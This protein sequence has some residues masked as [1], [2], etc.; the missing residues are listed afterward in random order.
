MAETKNIPGAWPLKVG[1]TFTLTRESNVSSTG[2]DWRLIR[3]KN[4]AL[5][6]EHLEQILPLVHG[7]PQADH[8]IGATGKRIWTFQAVAAGDGETQFAKYRASD[9]KTI[10]FDE[11]CPYSITKADAATAAQGG[12]GIQIETWLPFVQAGA[13]ILKGVIGVGV[14]YTPLLAS[15]TA[16]G[17]ETLVFANAKVVAPRTHTYPVA[18]WL[19]NDGGKPV[20]S[21]IRRIGEPRF[22]GSHEAFITGLSQAAKDAL[23]QAFE[24]HVGLDFTPL[25]MSIQIVAG[26]NILF[27]GNGKSVTLNGKERPL[28]VTVYQPP[29][30]KAEITDIQEIWEF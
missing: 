22:L 14:D 19:A 8:P 16:N 5:L 4:I 30:G 20:L 29:R 15:T 1:D 25:A 11:I 26:R 7:V 18:L 9:L 3:L 28:A 12:P 27:L 2:Y 17:N 6:E 23:A 24:H 10:L 21:A 13:D